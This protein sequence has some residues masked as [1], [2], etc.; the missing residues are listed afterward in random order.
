MNKYQFTIFTPVYNGIHTINRVWESLLSQTIKDFEWIIVNDG[1]TDG[2]ERILDEYKSKAFFPV[3]II[4]QQ[5]Q[6][7]HV[8]WNRAVE[9]AQGELFLP[10]DCDD[11]FVPETLG[12]FLKCW[13]E[14]P[15]EERPYFSG[16]NVLCKDPVKKLVIGDK[17]PQSL[18]VSNNL[19]LYY[20]H[21]IKG[22]KWGC[23][24]TDC[25]R[26]RNNPEI[27]GTHIPECWI[28]FWL[29]RRFKVLCINVPLR[30]YYHNEAGNISSKKNKET[31]LIRLQTNYVFLCWHLSDNIDY[32]I[33]YEGFI[34]ILKNF[35]IL[36]KESFYLKICSRRVIS[37]LRMFWPRFLAF[38]T[39]LPGLAYY[40]VS[41]YKDK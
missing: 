6:G 26:L 40:L 22:E 39:F 1:S 7:K 29:A 19:D 5:N 41:I 25:L 10:A 35:M 27:P 38:I 37:D 28:W 20:L 9:I 2:I 3:T 8:A 11:E 14:I 4:N 24:R 12:V 17:F 32:I 13:F 18:F 15:D 21:K 33:K 30:I 23:I 36:W 16:I 31:H 34:S